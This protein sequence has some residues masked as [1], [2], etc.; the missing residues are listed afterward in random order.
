M[1]ARVCTGIIIERDGEYLVGAVVGLN[2]LRWSTS[3]YDA[4]ITRKR[5]SAEKVSERVRGR[6][7][8]FNPIVGQLREVRT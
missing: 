8:L 5:G 4:W 3:P 7:M 1:D 6:Q 2:Q